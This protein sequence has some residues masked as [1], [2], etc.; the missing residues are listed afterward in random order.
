MY[1]RVIHVDIIMAWDITEKGSSSPIS[2]SD[3]MTEALLF[4]CFTHCSADES[5]KLHLEEEI[6]GKDRLPPVVDMIVVAE[7]KVNVRVTAMIF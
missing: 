1:Q 4:D 3:F 7:D 2:L 6:K 5:F